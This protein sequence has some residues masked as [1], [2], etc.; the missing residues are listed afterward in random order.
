MFSM[1][2]VMLMLRPAFSADDGRGELVECMT[3][4][5]SVQSYLEFVYMHRGTYPDSL[6]EMNLLFNSDVSRE[7]DRIVIPEDPASGKKFVYSPAKDLR[8]YVLSV[9]DPSLYRMEKLELRNVKWAWMDS[10]ASQINVEAKTDLC[11]RYLTALMKAAKK[12]QADKRKLPASIE[13]L[14]PAYVKAVPKC[15][16]CGKPYKI[17]LSDSDL[18]VSC[19]SPKSHGLAVFCCTIKKGAVVK[20]LDVKK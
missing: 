7:S 12:Y 16:L 19:P 17:T 1:A 9:P 18:S 13:D 10:V 4:M 15:P 5:S 14:V 2:A 6:E 20:P 3:R 11:G 8:S